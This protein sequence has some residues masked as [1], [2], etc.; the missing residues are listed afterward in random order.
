MAGRKT[1]DF[2]RRDWFY[3]TLEYLAVNPKPVSVTKLAQLLKSQQPII[4]RVIKTLD[5]QW[6]AVESKGD[7]KVL[8][9]NGIFLL[10]H[11]E[12]KRKR[13]DEDMKVVH[14]YSFKKYV[15]KWKNFWSDPPASGDFD[16]QKTQYIEYL[17]EYERNANEL[18]LAQKISIGKEIRENRV[19]KT[20]KF[21]FK[22]MAERM[23]RIEE[24]V[25]RLVDN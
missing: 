23:K 4:Y 9:H 2:E 15:E 10:C 5:E 19:E 11:L 22:E 12:Q 3:K 18:S 13:E 24:K 17:T 25:N 20:V 8:T 6:D 14:N 1:K 21:S 7:L 16:E